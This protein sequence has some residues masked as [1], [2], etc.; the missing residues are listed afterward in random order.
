MH[1]VDE[2]LDGFNNELLYILAARPG[3]GKTTLALN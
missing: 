1:C 2:L 3:V